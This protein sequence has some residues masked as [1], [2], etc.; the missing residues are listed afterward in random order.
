MNPGTGTTYAIAWLRSTSTSPCPTLGCVSG[1][2][3]DDVL[4]IAFHTSTAIVRSL[5]MDKQRLLESKIIRVHTLFPF[6]TF[7]TSINLSAISV[8]SIGLG[9]TFMT[10]CV[11][12]FWKMWGY[13]K[14][15]SLV[16]RGKLSI[17]MRI[18][19]STRLK[20]SSVR[21]GRVDFGVRKIIKKHRPLYEYSDEWWDV[22]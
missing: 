11:H 17:T 9:W 21:P 5:A 1:S 20:A 22:W 16:H 2:G 12:A 4:E 7:D 6:S 15:L 3:Y 14:L 19:S 13:R 10:F 18:A 8:I